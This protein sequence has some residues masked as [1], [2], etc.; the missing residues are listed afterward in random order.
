MI[1]EQISS[2]T[3]LLSYLTVLS[4]I[5]RNKFIFCKAFECV[6]KNLD[7]TSVNNI[8]TWRRIVHAYEET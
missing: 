7:F 5:S 3:A 4:V 6:F 2:A 1:I 8:S